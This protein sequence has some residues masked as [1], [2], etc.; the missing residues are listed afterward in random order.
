MP[1]K[2]KISFSELASR[3]G[4]ATQ[5]V[6]MEESIKKG[7]LFI[8]IPREKS[9]Q[10]NRIALTPEA[11]SSLVAGGHRIVIETKAGERSHFSDKDYSEAGADIAYEREQVYKADIIVKVAPLM[12]D[13][14]KLLKPHQIIL[15][16]IHLPTLKKEYI[17]ELMNKK[18]TALAFEYIKD[19]SGT[20]PIVRS[21]SEIAGTSSILI[22]AEYLNNINKGRGILFGGISGVP[23]AKVVILGAGVVGE[24]A[25][26]TALGLGVTVK[27]FDNSIYKLMR[28]QNNI[29]ARIFTSVLDSK[30][31]MKELENTDVAVG[32]IHSESGRTPIFVTEEMVAQMKPGSLIIDVSIDQ[33]G[34]FET[35]EVTD[36]EKPTF[37]KHDVT[38]YCVPNIASRVSRTASYAISNIL[39]PTLQNFS[40]SSNF[41]NALAYHI[42]AR[43]GVYLYKGSLTNQ[44]LGERFG[45]KFMDLDLLFAANI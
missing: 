44:H 43:H 19:E 37:I 17:T 3:F 32:A 7:K 15:S 2:K 6:T 13:E 41:E 8:G 21:M 31:L 10:E 30:T 11:I 33:G 34:C 26:R 35:S 12:S 5:E 18:I 39:T 40:R 27:V 1:E 14:I 42:G 24:F 20:F 38:H 22:A 25:T 45:L 28:L 36:H 29:G 4:T 16:P 23:P 9:F